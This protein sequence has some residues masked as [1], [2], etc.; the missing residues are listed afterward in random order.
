MLEVLPVGVKERAYLEAR[1][2]ANIEVD[3]AGNFYLV[4]RDAPSVT[5]RS[6]R[7]EEVRTAFRPSHCEHCAESVSLGGLY[8]YDFARYAPKELRIVPVDRAEAPDS[9]RS[10]PDLRNEEVIHATS[11]ENPGDAV[12]AI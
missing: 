2:G 6:A 10:D 9:V 4:H 1:F 7:L 5:L 3:R 11:T 12:A 8:L